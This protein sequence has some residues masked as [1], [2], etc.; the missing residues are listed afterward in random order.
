MAEE[1]RKVE[2]KLS[3]TDPM[4][5]KKKQKV[6]VPS[7]TEREAEERGSRE[8]IE[9]T[10]RQETEAGDFEESFTSHAIDRLI[11]EAQ[12]AADLVG[13]RPRWRLEEASRRSEFNEEKKEGSDREDSQK[14]VS[15][16]FKATNSEGRGVK[17]KDLSHFFTEELQV[18]IRERVASVRDSCSL[19]ELGPLVTDV[20]NLMEPVSH[21]CSSRSTAR[22]FELFPLPVNELHSL[23]SEAQPFLQALV[24]C[25]NS[26]HSCGEAR[27]DGSPSTAARGVLKRL[28][29][30]VLESHILKQPLPELDFS[31]FF[32]QKSL[33]YTGE[34]VR[35]AQS[36]SWLS[37]EASLPPEV[38]ALDIRE[39][40]DGGVLHFINNIGETIIPEGDQVCMR[41]PSVMIKDGEWELVAQGLV[42]RGLCKVV[43]EDELHRV[44]QQPLLNGL[45]SVSKDEVKDGIPVSRLIMNLKPWNSIS[46]SLAADVGT[47]PAITQIGTLYLH[48]G[49]VLVTSSEDLRCFFY[50]F[51]V[52]EAWC[53]FMGFGREI[54]K[55]MVP[56]G[57]ESKRWYL[58]GTVLPMGY[59]N[60]VGIAQHIHRLVVRRALGPLRNL[61][62]FPQEIRRDKVASSC[63]NLFRVYLDNFDQLQKVDRA[64]AEL[65]LGSPSE[66][67]ECL[68]E[69]YTQSALP[70]HP[71]KSVEQALEAEVQGAWVDGSLGTVSAKPSKVAKYVKLGLEVIAR[72][73]ASQR[74]L[75]VVGGGFVYIAMFRRPLLSSLN[76]IW[77]S[78]VDAPE[79]S[80]HSRFRLR[81]EV[82]IELVRFIGLCPLSFINLRSS[83]DEMVTASDASTTGGGICKSRGI[84]PYGQAACLSSVRGDIPEDLELT[85][86]LSI[87]L[88]DG[89]SALRVALD[90]LRIP[91]AG[92]ISVEK[93]EE[94]RRV[95]EANF[96]DCL[97]VE[98]VKNIDEEMVKVWSM[99]YASV[100]LVLIGSGPPCQGVS[101]LNA[102]RK[103]A[104]KDLRSKLFTEVPRVESLCR[105]HFPWAQVHTL[106]ENVA[107][108][109]QKD[110]AAMSEEFQLEPWFIDA[111]GV[112]L[113]H[114]PRLYWVSW[115]IHEAEGVEIYLGSDGRLPIQGQVVLK[116]EVVEKAFLEKGWKRKG[117]KPL[118][119]FTTSRPSPT[120]LR[121]PAGLK[122]CNEEELQRWRA[123][124]HRFPPYQ[125][126]TCHCLEDGQGSLRTPNAT[127]REAILG[128]PPNYTRQCMKKVHHGTEQHNDCRLTLTGNSWSVGVVAWLISQLMIRLGIMS[129]LSLQDIVDNLTPGKAKD[130]QSLLLRPPLS[131]NNQ[132]FSPNTKLVSKLAGLVSIKGEDLMLQGNSEIPVRYHRLRSEVPAKLWRWDTVPGWQWGGDPE[133]INVLEARAVL[134]TIKWRVS[135]RKQINLR[136]V[137]LVDSL[138][139][140]HALTRGRSSSRKMRRTMMRINYYLLASGLQPLWAYVDTKEN[141]ADRPSRWG[142]RKRWVK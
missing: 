121:R 45:F 50:L 68:R 115:E 88:F 69:Y 124:K 20:L 27:P 128:F 78:I 17:S 123:D 71:K 107:S 47:L 4:H 38:G 117:E 112:S 129:P 64:T 92:H 57:G 141:P 139:C 21:R 26:L 122:D 41:C 7:E 104:L 16:E 25:L 83:F 108:M 8:D 127:E 31:T 133:H 55:S 135:Q 97:H 51:K 30:V 54:P 113:A 15:K 40:C 98:D 6:Q 67:V 34:E 103:G 22:K 39:F 77:R 105:K 80:P 142:V 137:H 14:R 53:K 3:P 86:V 13:A 111:E 33:D 1:E 120:P 75:Q 29:R 37:I 72:G 5:R 118:P 62:P 43:C 84:T 130:L 102:D 10:K 85:Q 52:P 36:I 87:G 126:K 116:A 19:G 24:R 81:K 136:C 131:Q 60:S 79:K 49:D 114:R 70:R 2:G 109:D 119:T 11:D 65:L 63:P 28:E 125:Y 73:R 93:N 61:E 42:S 12:K 106:T 82:M 138:V 110:C 94:A 99:K 32:T 132:T 96:P 23:E 48:D 134:T 89:I 66:L 44:G 100:G 9:V 95:V 74:E 35:L 90:A 140:L 58:A 91:V 18:L 56:H 101:G 76:H 46:R 59:L